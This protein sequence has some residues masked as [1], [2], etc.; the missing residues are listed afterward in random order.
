MSDEHQNGELFENE[1]ELV[2]D[3]YTGPQKDIVDDMEESYIAYAM[4]VIVARAL[5]DVR[6]GLK[7]VHRR[8]L[9]AMLE[10]GL[11][12]GAKYRKSANVVGAVLGKYHPHGDSAV[13]MSMV[14]MAQD[15]SLRYPLVDGQGN[16]GSIDG[17]NPAAM[18]YTEAR[19]TRVSE[20]MLRDIEKDTVDF[21][22][23]YDATA[24]E[25][26]VLPSVLPQLLLNGT[27]GIAV[28]MATNIPPHNMKEVVGA[29]IELLENPEA[30]VD[31][32]LKHVQG[33]DFPTAGEIYDGGAIK[34]MY[35]TGR[36]RVIMRAKTHI[37]EYKKDR[38]AIIVT[39]I[40]Y[41]VN[42]ADLIIKIADL[43][44][45]K[46]LVSIADLRD[47]SNREG[48][49]VVIELKKDSFPKKV[50]NKLFKL[51]PL[52]K[53]F[54]LNMIALVD[55]VHPR[56]LNLKQV[57]E[58]FLE[59]RFN[60][61]V[62]KTQFELNV[63][64]A[65]AHVL[66]GLKIALDN[67]DEVIAII[68]GSETKELAAENLQSKFG[69]SERQTKAIL[70]MRLQTL[71]GLERQKIEDEL[72]EKMALITDLKDILSSRDRQQ[73]IIKESMLEA[74]EKYDNPRRTVVHPNALGKFS[75]K[76][77]IP[78]EDM[79]VVLTE[80]NY[81]KRLSPSTFRTQKR[82]GVGVVGAKTKDED[83]IVKA[84]F[85]TNHNDLLFFTSLGRVFALPMYEI[86]EASRTAKGTPIINLLQLQKGEKVTEILNLSQSIGDH[87]FFCTTGGT[88]KR[89]SLE[90]FANIRRSGLIACGLKGDEQL[91]WAKVSSEEDEIFIV[92]REGKSIRFKASEI[93]S[94]GRSA[95][96]VR[97]IRLKD[98]DEVVQ[99]DILRD[100]NARL[101]VVM[102]NGLGK[103]SKVDQYRE[104]ARGGT[105]VKVA[106]IT[107]KTGKVAG[108]RVVDSDVNEADLLLVTQKGQT[109]RTKISEIK[110][111]GRATQGVI[112][113]RP[114]EGDKISSI[115]LIVETQ[116]EE[117]SGDKDQGQLL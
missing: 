64:E 27:M 56:L 108:A 51:T 103:M 39:E 3:S 54:N 61:V 111:A 67:I 45:D 35:S 79:I 52:Q 86:P 73:K 36:G 11:R 113:M 48:I 104:Q 91:L 44:R 78:D 92:S 15:F 43:V 100:P 63:A 80:Q 9:Y 53:S 106:N 30:T 114:A 88:V 109:M 69:L 16:F 82:G 22:D 85:G 90:Q 94:M 87:I 2:S 6:D 101:L 18:R 102:E 98:G 23:N 47:E 107:K 74:C 55:G 29:A 71:A 19:M 24:K 46:K 25:P 81:V 62:R 4:S 32:L 31:D 65:R 70:D 76:D 14:R 28:G 99:M 37:E 42:K 7:P 89:T 83:R 58:Y 75:A 8:I 93:R 66:E 96:G 110:T 33:P 60:V 77:T 117:V 112:I 38:F 59:H 26:T 1:N 41:Q 50:L 10:N 49:R 116:N 12:A 20:T 97:G 105:G 34:E 115:S 13:Y 72:A 95:A 17:D 21:R 5:P 57:L 40:P 68:R 84:R